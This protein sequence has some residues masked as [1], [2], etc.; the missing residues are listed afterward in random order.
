[1][2]QVTGPLRAD[3]T[4][5]KAQIVEAAR[6]AFASNGL[7][8]SMAEIAR[9]AGVGFA[10]VQRRFPTKVDLIREIV[11]AE[12]ADLS[13][14]MTHPAS[15]SDASDEFT[16]ALRACTSHQAAQPGLAGAIADAVSD[17][18]RADP[19]GQIAAAFTSAAQRASGSGQLSTDITLDDVLAILYG[20]AGVVAHSPGQE[21]AASARFVEIALRGLRA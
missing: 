1:M 19:A 8:V 13:V 21:R 18:V 10:T 4:R 20:N 15:A 11:L 6:T 16:T 9:R 17:V 5:N 12:I 3:A 2:A 7:D 14:A